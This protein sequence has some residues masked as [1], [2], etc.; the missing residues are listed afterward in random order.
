MYNLIMSQ[1]ENVNISI[2]ALFFIL[3]N[4]P[5][6]FVKSSNDLFSYS[7]NNAANRKLS[8]NRYQMLLLYT[9]EVE[10]TNGVRSGR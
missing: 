5:E 10:K 7:C 3:W 1:Q 2:M 8:L 9:K 6:N 4:F